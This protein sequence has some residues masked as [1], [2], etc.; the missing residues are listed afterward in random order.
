MAGSM[1]GPSTPDINADQPVFQ[2]SPIE[3]A[4]YTCKTGFVAPGNTGFYTNVC[5]NGVW[6]DNGYCTGRIFL[7]INIYKTN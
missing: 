7:F 2:G 3:Q 6:E 1:C 5:T 4:T